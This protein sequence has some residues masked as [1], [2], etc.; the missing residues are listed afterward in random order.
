MELI[1]KLGI[2]C[3]ILI[4]CF[5]GLVDCFYVYYT[6]F[7]HDTTIGV[8]NVDNQIG[9]D[10]KLKEDL[11]EQE[12][13]EYEERYFMT[14][15][16]YS[17]SKNNGVELQELR[18][19]YFMDYTLT[20]E[21]YRSTGMQYLGNFSGIK[22]SNIKEMFTIR[23]VVA[24]FNYYET[25]NGISWNGT[26]YKNGSI[27]SKLSRDS[28][29]II[30]IDN[31]PFSIQ[32]T[33]KYNVG[34]WIFD[35][36]DYYDYG[37][38][39]S[40]VFKVIKSNSKGFGDYYITLDLSDYFTIKEY[41]PETGKFKEDDVTDIIKN[42]AVL[43]FHYD[44]NGAKDVNQSLYKIIDC[45]PSYGLSEY[46]V[47]TNYFKER[48]IIN[49]NES[50]LKTRYSNVNNGCYLY[51]DVKDVELLNHASYLITLNID[52]DSDIFK[53]KVIL[54]IDY[55]G[56]KNVRLEK[57]TITSKHN[58]DF[59][60]L[61]NSLKDTKLNT[62]QYSRTVNLFKQDNFINTNYVEVVL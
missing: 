44:E 22:S 6:Q 52:L 15:N 53:D 48:L 11:S 16:Y 33:G 57:L 38:I 28:S 25:T 30:K 55:D 58:K 61:E 51:I 46:D 27:A 14:A 60:L 4:S 19:D 3:L 24:L 20:S 7:N 17:N 50:F 5:A 8:N 31:R 36:W 12:Q 39:F 29:M 21:K 49:L 10:I 62:L 18:F 13:A 37:D 2:I 56:F 23:G 35:K 42:Y 9:L 32:L 47:D 26:N 54:G 1:K 43:K 34:W 59:Y 45:N 40:C 41:D